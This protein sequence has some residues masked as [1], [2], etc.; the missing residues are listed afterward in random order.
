M[1]KHLLATLAA[2]FRGAVTPGATWAGEIVD[3]DLVAEVTVR[4][5]RRVSTEAARDCRE[6]ALAAL[7]K[8]TFRVRHCGCGVQRRTGWGGTRAADCSGRVVAAVAYTAYYSG[9]TTYQFVCGRHR[10]KPGIRPESIL[11]VVDLTETSLRPIREQDELNKREWDEKC[12]R[13]EEER[14]RREDEERA[15]RK[16]A[17]R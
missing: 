10:D 17:G 7:R 12:R 2:H 3:G 4:I 14:C 15:A 8:D 6:G 9:E 13:E 11:A 16:G 1:R 5:R